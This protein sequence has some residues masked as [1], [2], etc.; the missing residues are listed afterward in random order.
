MPKIKPDYSEA[1][2]PLEAGT[3]LCRVVSAEIK[4]GKESGKHYVNWKLETVNDNLLVYYST[5][6]EGR[7]AGMFKHFVKCIDKNYESGEFDTD[8]CIGQIISADLEIEEGE[9]NGRPFKRFK[10]TNIN[11]ST[12]E[13]LESL[14]FEPGSDLEF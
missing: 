3:Y 12:V 8:E 10:V 9:Y 1:V 5:P 2:K 14:N 13:Q 4:T 6:V 7:G 11:P